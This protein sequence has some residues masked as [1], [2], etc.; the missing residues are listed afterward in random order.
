MLDGFHQTVDENL[1]TGQTSIEEVFGFALQ[2][3][4]C[5]FGF[6][7]DLAGA[8]LGGANHFGALHHALGLGTCGFDDFVGFALRASEEGFFF[9]E[10]ES[11]FTHFMRQT[12]N[13]VF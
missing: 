7:D 8:S 1:D 2:A 3:T 10:H 13:C 11:C 9:F 12:G 6:V 5:G 4:R